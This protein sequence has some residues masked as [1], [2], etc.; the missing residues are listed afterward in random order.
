MKFLILLLIFVKLS[1]QIRKAE[2][3]AA[4]LR[5]G[6]TRQPTS[7]GARCNLEKQLA[8]KEEQ[9]RGLRVSE[10][11]VAREKAQRAQR[12]KLAIF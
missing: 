12:D 8:V 1:E 3:E 5:Q 2:R 11:S 4:R 9:I 7:S 10:K 6:I